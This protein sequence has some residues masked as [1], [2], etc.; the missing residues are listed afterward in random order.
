MTTF[1]DLEP[2]YYALTDPYDP[3]IVLAI[4]IRAASQ[5][6]VFTQYGKCTEGVS[7]KR[8]QDWFALVF[9]AIARDTAA[10]RALFVEITGKCYVCGRKLTDPNSK[11][12]GIGPDC[13]AALGGGQ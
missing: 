12:R 9:A 6:P 3:G 13:W 7:R 11:A 4:R 10:T 8:G 2:G 1:L 5:R